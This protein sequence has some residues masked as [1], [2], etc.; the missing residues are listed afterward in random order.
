MSNQLERIKELVERRA[1]A[2]TKVL[3]ADDPA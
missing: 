1:K 2:I 3:F